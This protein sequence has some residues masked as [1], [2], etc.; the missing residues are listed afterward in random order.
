MSN[1]TTKKTPARTARKTDKLYGIGIADGK[2]AMIPDKLQGTDITWITHKGKV[3]YTM[4]TKENRYYAPYK[5]GYDARTKTS[6]MTN[7]SGALTISDL[8]NELLRS[9]GGSIYGGY[10]TAAAIMDKTNESHQ[11]S[12]AYYKLRPVSPIYVMQS[13]PQSLSDYIY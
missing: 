4:K 1:N 11:R 5:F 7:L 10:L 6:Y 8:K 13:I 12:V 2:Y 9:T 3:I